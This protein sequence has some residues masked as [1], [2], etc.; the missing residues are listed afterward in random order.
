MA[1]ISSNAT[2]NLLSNQDEKL[3]TIQQKIREQA[4]LE[5]FNTLLLDKKNFVDIETTIS[6]LKSHDKIKYNK[7]SSATFDQLISK[8]VYK[9]IYE[10]YK[11]SDDEEKMY[12]KIAER[13]ILD[14]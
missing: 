13:I 6:K 5:I 2:V 14:T 4:K 7:S 10:S 11:N 12:M 8:D 3:S 1:K 9:K